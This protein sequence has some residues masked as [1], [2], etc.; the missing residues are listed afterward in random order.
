[1]KISAFFSTL[2]LGSTLAESNNINNNNRLL[3]GEHAECEICGPGVE[4]TK[5]DGILGGDA[6]NATCAEAAAAGLNGDIDPLICKALQEGLALP[7]CGCGYEACSI[8]GAGSIV[9]NPD[10]IVSDPSL[11]DDMTCAELEQE[12]KDAQLS[13]FQCSNFPGLVG[14]ICGCQAAPTASPTLAPTPGPSSDDGDSSAGAVSAAV[15]FVMSLFSFLA[16][17]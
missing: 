5:P 9:T 8:C 2:I 17:I 7:V 6:I 16:A 11:D 10:A 13:P 1:M 14:G 3:Q 4:F 15:A 12:G